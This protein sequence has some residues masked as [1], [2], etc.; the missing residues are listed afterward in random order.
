MI[1]IETFFSIQSY[2]I[3]FQSLID[4]SEKHDIDLCPQV[5]LTD[6]E[7]AVINAVQLEF[8]N[9]QHKRYANIFF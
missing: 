1:S 4:F 8:D 5:V 6:F 3:L 2:R 9:I 7:L